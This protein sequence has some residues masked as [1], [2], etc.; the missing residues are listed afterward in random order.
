MQ[1]K[2]GKDGKDGRDG[3]DNTTLQIL[4]DVVNK[5]V[6][7]GESILVENQLNVIL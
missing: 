3:R 6:E 2:D 4:N 7:Q 1:G 5:N